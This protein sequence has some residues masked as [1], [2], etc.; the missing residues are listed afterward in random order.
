MKKFLLTAAIAVASYFAQATNKLVIANL[1]AG[2]SNANNFLPTGVPQSGDEV[3]VPLGFTITVKGSIYGSS[4]PSIK[5]KIFGTLDF[6]P[7][8]KLNL[9]ATSILQ[10]YALGKITTNG[11]SSEIITIGGITKYNG[12]NDGTLLGPLFAAGGPEASTSLKPG[13]G[14]LAGVLPIRFIS[15][16]G[17]V[18]GSEVELAW[19]TSA[20]ADVEK[21]II[22]RKNSN[23]W[24]DIQ[25]IKTTAELQQLY[26]FRDATVTKKANSY[27]I[28]M[29]GK[30][31]D[32][33]YSNVLS[34]NLTTALPLMSVT[35]N[36]AFSQAIVSWKNVIKKGK[37]VLVNS[38]GTACFETEIN[39]TTTLVNLN[40]GR[41]NKGI[42]QIL[43]W[44]RDKIIESKSIIHY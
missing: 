11:T 28:K 27:R 37:L 33:V 40:L 15:F 26:S 13:S 6:D 42:Y 43:I 20:S 19:E 10:I 2:W 12:Q 9:A 39:S 25:A 35:P 24:E 3:T 32:V 8:G 30:N 38:A 31:G 41:L 18:H 4:N 29:I 44:S 36:P 16:E 21:F 5:L 7:S 34:F 23:D 14:F 1:G 17:R 22:Q